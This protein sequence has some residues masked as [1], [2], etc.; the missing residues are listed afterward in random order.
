MQKHTEVIHKEVKGG[1][2]MINC[3]LMENQSGFSETSRL[4]D[5]VKENTQNRYQNGSRVSALGDIDHT[6][7]DGC[8]HTKL[9]PE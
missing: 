9:T 7:K 6:S 8:L 5:L 3:Y 4:E 2:K 1:T